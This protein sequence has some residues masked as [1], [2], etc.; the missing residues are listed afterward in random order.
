[1]STSR[2]RQLK[3]LGQGSGLQAQ[4]IRGALGVGGLKLLSLS[5]TLATSV[6]LARGLG[7]EGYGQYTFI[8]AVV[9]IA[10]LPVAQGLGQLITREVARYHQGQEWG[11]FR[12]LLRRAHQWVLAGSAALIIS[13]AA[14]STNQATW[15]ADDRWTLMIVSTLMIPL[16]GLNAVRT[17]TLRG[18][19]HVFQAQLPELLA[20][21]GLHFMIGGILLVLGFLNPATALI[22]QIGA[23]A[24]AFLLGAWILSRYSPGNIKAAPPRYRNQEW[25]RAILPF[26]ML[27]AV[28]TM[29]TQI[30]ILALGWLGTDEQVAILQI[31]QRGAM[32]VMLSLTIVNLIIGPHITRAHREEDSKKLQQLSRQSARA[33]LAVSLPVALPLIF[34]GEPIVNIVFGDAY[35]KQSAWPLA[36]LTSGQLINVAF[37][38]VGM[39]LTMTGYERDTLQG[40]IIALL[41]NVSV[42]IALIPLFG[43]IGAAL[44]V[45]I[46][47]LVWNIILALKFIKRLHLRPTAL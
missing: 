41:V 37:G 29:N 22:S 47:L 38:S 6:L 35:A 2:F 42:A 18:L 33:A 15:E 3:Q 31:S 11:L 5:L 32:L 16:L 34:I 27:A 7:P 12:G 19:R 46:G 24:A 44:A 39:F 14:F 36:I 17:S 30:G 45:S 25:R 10:S 21:P 43:A 9:S 4:L 8:M 40:Q 23:T 26:T 13:I 20:R 1:M 28:S